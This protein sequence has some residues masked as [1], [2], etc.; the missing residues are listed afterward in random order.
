MR[1][2][3]FSLI[4]CCVAGDLVGGGV[5]VKGSNWRY[6]QGVSTPLGGWTNVAFADGVW[7]GPAPSGFGYG[8]GDDATVFGNMQN[9]YASVYLRH[10]FHI[11]NTADVTHLTLAV[12]YDD[13]FV[14]YVN[15]QEVVRQNM[16]T[17]VVTHATVASSAHA[18]SRKG[19]AQYST[20]LLPNPREFFS[21]DPGLLVVGSNV[22]AVSGH[23]V[24]IG[25]TDFSLI[26]E[27]FTNVTLLRG[28]ILQMQHSGRMSV[29][30]R[31]DALTDSVVDYGT[32][33][34]YGTGTVTDTNLVREHV[35]ELPALPPGA[36][37]FYRVRSAGLTLAESSFRAPPNTNQPYRF[38]IIGDFGVAGVGLIAVANQVDA[39]NP[40]LQLTAGDN[41]YYSGQPGSFDEVWFTPYSNVNRRAPVMPVIGNHDWAIEEGRWTVDAFH[42]PTNG[43]AGLAERVYSYDY[44]NA[45]F[46]GIDSNPFQESDAPKMAAIAAWVAQDLAATTQTW[47]FVSFHHPPYTSQGSHLD[48]A[49]VKAQLVPVL[50]QGGVDVVFQGHNHFYER[51]NPI[52]GVHYI[53]SGGGG[54][55]LYPISNRREFSASVVDDTFSCAVVDVNGG[56]LA[57]RCIDQW[58]VVRDSFVY[59][60]DHPFLMDGLIDSTNWV[61]AAN[62]LRLNAAI[63]KQYLYLATQDA[64]EGNDHFIYVSNM[65]S[66]SV[67]ANWSKS[68]QVMQWSAFLA[69]ENGGGGSIGGAVSWFGPQQQVLTNASQYRATT[70][71]LNNN[72]TNVN[73]VLEGTLELVQHYG[74]FPEQLFLAAAPYVTTNQGGLITGA[75]VPVG[76]GDGHIQSNE[77]L[78]VSTRAITL[79]LPVASAGSAGS[80]ES[81]MWGL[82]DGSGSLAPS[83]LGLTYQWVQIDG[84]TGEVFNATQSQA[85]FRLAYD[86][87][88]PTGVVIQL[89]VHDTRFDTNDTVVLTV[90]PRLDSDSDGLSDQEE[91]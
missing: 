6:W 45:H 61:R 75:Q 44:G 10:T 12:D 50:E 19:I 48:N 91:L 4:G 82:L 74:A 39:A 40:D 53:T 27:L 3:I 77:F 28:P 70:S 2:L 18:A 68:G 55:F 15:G 80:V 71:G 59:A 32:D 56:Q 26:P 67:P 85:S 33:A 54:Q 14:A 47:K 60:V 88:T 35:V 29:T 16:P 23:N 86:I 89:T 52:N 17:G 22:L 64:G 1:V 34:G 37:N 79:D 49:N 41:V 76:N 83:G 42:L 20:L 63:R 43:P 30:W 69:D 5:V 73:G 51:I 25:S 57:V 66:N 46:V 8:D 81:G 9:T 7:G 36:T 58:G 90:M 62:G 87:G 13:G 84:P 72:G 78:A 65:L 31:T 24:S 38:S 21:L 11:A